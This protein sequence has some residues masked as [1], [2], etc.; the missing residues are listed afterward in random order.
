MTLKICLALFVTFPRK[1]VRL[2]KTIN[3]RPYV[4]FLYYS[5]SFCRAVN[6]LNISYLIYIPMTPYPNDPIKN[7]D[8]FINEGY[9]NDV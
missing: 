5:K 2:N 8:G 9:K 1:L 7:Y 6:N 4:L 3:A